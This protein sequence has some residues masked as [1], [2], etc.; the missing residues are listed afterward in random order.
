MNKIYTEVAPLVDSD[1]QR[2][3]DNEFIVDENTFK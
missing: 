2:C 1:K 3:S